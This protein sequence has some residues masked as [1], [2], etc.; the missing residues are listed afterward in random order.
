MLRGEGKEHGTNGVRGWPGRIIWV[1]HTWLS[2][3]DIQ[4]QQ[5]VDEGAQKKKNGHT[6]NAQN[7]AQTHVRKHAKH[8]GGGRE[9]SVSAART[10]L[11]CR[12]HVL[13]HPNRR[14]PPA[15]LPTCSL[16]WFTSHHGTLLD[17][18]LPYD[19]RLRSVKALACL[20]MLACLL[21]SI[22]IRRR[23]GE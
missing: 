5:K 19:A 2:H 12:C 18:T 7:T 22:M 1:A 21:C 15:Q 11:P 10:L 6:D 4:L 13:S 16:P 3:T 17:S 23:D 14:T 20:R 8:G 9:G